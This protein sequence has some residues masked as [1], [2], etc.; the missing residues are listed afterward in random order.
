MELQAEKPQLCFWNVR[1]CRH[2]AEQEITAAPSKPG[3]KSPLST[4]TEPRVR[5]PQDHTAHV[6]AL[7]ME[8][9][10]SPSVCCQHWAGHHHPHLQFVFLGISLLS[11]SYL[12]LFRGGLSLCSEC[13]PGRA[14]TLTWCSWV[15]EL[16]DVVQE[17]RWVCGIPSSAKPSAVKSIMLPSSNLSGP[18]FLPAACG[19]R[20]P[21]MQ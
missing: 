16:P 1:L 8:L 2:T 5:S 14:P 6:S 3:E 18:S 11:S 9:D 20:R 15:P 10:F 7:P 21:A 4:E 12:Q 13:Q 17:Q 19:N